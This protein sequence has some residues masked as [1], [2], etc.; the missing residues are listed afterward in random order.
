MRSLPLSVLSIGVL[1]ALVWN[2]HSAI[3]C[4]KKK[5]KKA[6]ETVQA[7]ITSEDSIRVV[8]AP[9]VPNPAKHDSLKHA[10]KIA[11]LKSANDALVVSFI[12]L[13]SGIDIEAAQRFENE[14]VAFN[15]KSDCGI[16]YEQKNWGRE[17]ERDYC[18]LSSDEKCMTDFTKMVKSKFSGNR[19]ILIKEHSTCK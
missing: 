12:S 2:S 18:V 6:T 14:L 9:G 19:R 8:R 4:K 5:K 13:A 3:A 16:L 1:L 15:K 7:V 10:N 11:K 17:G